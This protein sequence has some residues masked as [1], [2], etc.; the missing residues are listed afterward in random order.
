MHLF[1]AVVAYNIICITDNICIS[2]LVLIFINLAFMLY[3]GFYFISLLFYG[4]L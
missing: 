2:V 4:T 3:L 1:S